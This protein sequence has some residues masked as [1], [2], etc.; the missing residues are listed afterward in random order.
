MKNPNKTRKPSTTKKNQEKPRK[1]KKKKK[2]QG[3]SGTKPWP[4]SQ[5]E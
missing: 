5:F 3:P 4:E 1:S 2:K